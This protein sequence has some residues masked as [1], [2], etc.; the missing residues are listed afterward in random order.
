MLPTPVPFDMSTVHRLRKPVASTTALTQ[1]KRALTVAIVVALAIA[2]ALAYLLAGCGGGSLATPPP[3][4]PPPPAFQALTATEVTSIATSAA[5]SV[6]ADTLV[7]A[8]V[9]GF[10]RH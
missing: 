9:D 7:I 4:P 5:A 8:V 1:H 10:V 2:G 3:P 6:S